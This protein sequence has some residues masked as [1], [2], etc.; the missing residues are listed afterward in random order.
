MSLQLYFDGTEFPVKV[1][2]F[3]GGEV[4]VQLPKNIPNTSI[5]NIIANLHSSDDVM[6]L[7]MLTSALRNVFTSETKI[8]LTMPYIPYARQDRVCGEGEALAIKVFCDLIN[9]QKYF[10]V[11]IWD[12]H[13]DVAIALL[14]NCYHREQPDLLKD[15]YFDKENTILVSPDAGANKKIFKVAKELGFKEVVRADKTRN[16]TTGEITGTVVYCENVGAKDFLIVDD[17]CDGGRTFIEAC[18]SSSSA[19]HW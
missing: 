3:S 9:S 17:I 13:S 19:Y 14:N 7:L 5:A 4:Q 11:E 1:F 18:K 2:N 16:V 6:A 12:S 8:F 10:G 15:L